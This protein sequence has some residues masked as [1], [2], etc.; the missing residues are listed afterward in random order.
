MQLKLI[1]CHPLVGSV[2]VAQGGGG[3]GD[4]GG[5]LGDGAEAVTTLSHCGCQ[6]TGFV[7]PDCVLSTLGWLFCGILCAQ[8]A[9]AA[10]RRTNPLMREACL[11][12]CR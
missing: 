10:P 12:A 5:G 8:I 2:T 6:A 11:F 1:D 9:A 3:E 7:F 4:G